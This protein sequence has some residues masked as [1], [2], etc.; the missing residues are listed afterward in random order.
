MGPLCLTLIPV[1]LHESTDEKGES[2]SLLRLE[3]ARISR[4][5]LFL[6]I[7]VEA[8][9]KMDDHGLLYIITHKCVQRQT[10]NFSNTNT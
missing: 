9:A 2:D 1:V 6:L 3:R 10:L 8:G 4:H 7:L 5:I